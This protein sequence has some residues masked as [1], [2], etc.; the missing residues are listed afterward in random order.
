MRRCGVAQH[1][2]EARLVWDL[3]RSQ[4]EGA[5]GLARRQQTR[6]AALVAH[7]RASSRFY[8]R[9]YRDRALDSPLRDLPP[10]TKQ[11][12]MEAFDDW[13]T[14]PLVTRAAVETFIAEPARLGAKLCEKYFVCSTSGTTGEPGRF[15]HDEHAVAVYRALSMRLFGAWWS[16][17]GAWALARKGGRLVAVVGTGGHFAG[18]GWTESE[19]SRDALRSHA[20]S[21]ISVQRPLA[22]IVAML[23][24]RDPAVLIVY[25]SALALLAEEQAAGRLK[26]QLAFIELGGE[27]MAPEARARAAEVFGCAIYDI[28]SASEAL[29]MAVDCPHGQLHV[30]SDWM[31]LEP[32][33]AD[34]KPVPPGQPSHTVLLTNLANRVQPILRYD[35]GDS[36]VAPTDPC[37]CGSPLPPLRVL[38][39]SSDLLSFAS[40]GGRK[41]AIAPSALGVILATVSGARRLQLVQTTP[42][43]LRLRVEPGHGI[44]V[45]R[46]QVE[47]IAKVRAYLVE[48][49]LPNV[50]IVRATETPEP[51]ARSGKFRQIVPL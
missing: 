37:P 26:L 3:F 46:T 31:I 2:S 19:R 6:L 8:G 20:Y 23:N 10:V 32:V 11:E 27:S 41:V 13:V 34:L 28:Y 36:V 42:T 51:S 38:G 50:E 45:E 35:L 29:L 15:V 39:R 22:E 14:D 16:A 5:T 18:E 21:V 43:S 30:N 7:A 47:A 44:D 24:D 25:P 40:A 33:D 1:L 49:G 9:H 12:L 4:R 17:A 48:Q